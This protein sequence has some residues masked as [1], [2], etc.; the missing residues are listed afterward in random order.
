MG[1][2][3]CDR[4]TEKRKRWRVPYRNRRASRRV[5]ACIHSKGHETICQT[6]LIVIITTAARTL[7]RHRD[8]SLRQHTRG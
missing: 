3:R 6:D 2:K 1:A 4:V 5:R 8:R 7:R